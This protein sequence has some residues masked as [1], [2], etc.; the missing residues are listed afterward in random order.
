M[1]GPKE[2]VDRWAGQL[3]TKTDF[4]KATKEITTAGGIKGLRVDL[5]GPKDPAGAGGP[6]MRGR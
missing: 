5:T 1:G 6:F 3:G 2:N 4:A